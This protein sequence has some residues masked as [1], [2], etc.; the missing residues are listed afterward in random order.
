MKR[1]QRHTR[2]LALALLLL[3]A[4][5][6]A[7]VGKVSVLEGRAQRTPA[8]GAKAALQ[9]GSDIE[10][11]DTLEVGP[12]SNLKLTLS[13]RSVI[14]LGENSQLRIDEATFEGQERKGFSATLGFGKI[15]SRVEKM[16]AGP[17]AK[18]EVRTERAVA[19]VRGTIFRVD[20]V[21]VVGATT[22]LSRRVHTVVRVVEG[23]VAVQA[24]VKRALKGAQP[25]GKGPR[26]QV[27]GPTQVSAEQWERRFVE[28]QANQQVSVGEELWKEAAVDPASRRDAF[29]RFVDRNP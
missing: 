13:D 19:G 12:R 10:L 20:A 25:P 5:A 18:F 17:D 3:P 2:S 26:V 29:A 8:S 24:Q 14:M 1:A 11:G 9:V 27:P 6:L 15:W 7:S 4:L 16:M 21:K 22:Q 23:R 28:L